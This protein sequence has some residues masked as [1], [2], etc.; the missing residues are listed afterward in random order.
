MSPVSLVR[1]TFDKVEFRECE[2]PTAK[3]GCLDANDGFY[4]FVFSVRNRP[5]EEFGA[6]L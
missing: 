3:R 6:K 4:E 1:T 2:S 5:E